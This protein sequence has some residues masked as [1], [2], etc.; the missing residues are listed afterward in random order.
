VKL[1]G[2]QSI[3]PPKLSASATVS[4]AKQAG[5]A[6]LRRTADGHFEKQ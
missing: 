4:I 5:F 2:L 3:N 6:V 1:H